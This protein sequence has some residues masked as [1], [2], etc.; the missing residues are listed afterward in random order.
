MTLGEILFVVVL[1]HLIAAC[2]GFHLGDRKNACWIGMGLGLVFGGVGLIVAVLIDNRDPCPVCAIR[3]GRG[4][5]LCP[6]CGTRLVDEKS[7]VSAMPPA[8]SGGSVGP[9]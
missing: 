4:A 3:L 9:V 7:D 2:F 6:G 5:Q 8:S 1:Q